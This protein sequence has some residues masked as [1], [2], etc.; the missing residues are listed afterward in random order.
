LKARRSYYIHQKA[1]VET[2]HI[3]SGTR[4][5]AFAHVL[6]GAEIGIDCN[7]GDHCYIEGG[8]KIGNE[9]V[10]KNGVS[11]W[12]GITIGDRVFIG[13]N[14]VFTN[15]RVPRAKIYR[16]Q[17]DRTVVRQGASIGANVTLLC[18]ITVG[19]YAMIGAGSVV[20]KDVPDFGLVFG[21]PAE[22]RGFVCQCGERLP[23]ELSAE[24]KASCT[25]G[26]LFEKVADCIRL[27]ETK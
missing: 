15:D 27:G 11:V 9:V 19:C 10:I 17:Y 24:G 16:E 7:I 14:V 5:W 26:L 1:L 6:K 18:P 20:T 25:C 22:I 13:P 23:F 4:I 3:G 21:N 8:A 2:D 12:K